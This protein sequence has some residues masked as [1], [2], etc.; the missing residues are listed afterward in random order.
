MILLIGIPSE[1]PM[2]MVAAALD[3]L[4]LPYVIWNQRRI[5]DCLRV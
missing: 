3:E 2:R 4:N 1:P 5:A